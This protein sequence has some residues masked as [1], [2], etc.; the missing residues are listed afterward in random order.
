VT[1]AASILAPGAAPPATGAAPIIAPPG[2]PPSDQPN[3][4]STPV[5][6]KWLGENPPD[7]IKGYVQNKGWK[8]PLEVL[9]GYRNLE[10]LVGS[11]RLAMPK[12]EK[13]AEGWGKVYDAL[14]R[15]KA[16]TEYKLP[17]PEG[18]DGKFAEVAAGVF[19]KA[20]LSTKQATEIATWWNDAQTQAAKAEAEAFAAKSEQEIVALKGEWGGAYNERVETAKRGLRMFGIDGDKASALEKVMGTKGLMQFAYDLGFKISEHGAPGMESQQPGTGGALTP[21]QAQAEITR[22]K[23]D[24]SW[25]KKYLEGDADAKRRMEQLQQWAYPSA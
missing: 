16:P 11:H 23:A 2:T 1:G 17:V 10:K 6:V 4:N 3:P 19:H 5:D 15:P 7:E 24:V 9:D 8:N 22:L 12:D 13:D 25:S 20:G 18:H 14:G 21:Q